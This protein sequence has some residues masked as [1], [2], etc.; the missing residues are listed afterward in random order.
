MHGE[1]T[2]EQTRAALQGYIFETLRDREWRALDAHLRACPAC[3]EVLEAEQARLAALDALP[4]ESAPPGLAERTLARMPVDADSR[5][6]GPRWAPLGAAAGVIVLLA[7]VLIPV[8]TQSRE[9]ARR[10]STQN[11]MKQLGLVFKMYGNESEGEQ[12]PRLA[13]ATEAWAPELDPLRGEFITDPDILVS[14]QHPEQRTLKQ[15][16]RDAWAGSAPDTGTAEQLM[17]ESFGYLGYTIRNEDDFEALRR[18][19]H[20]GTLPPP[21]EALQPDPDRDPILPLREGIERFLITDIN[22]PAATSASQSTIPVLVEIATW[23]YKKS[24]DRYKGANVLYMDGHVEFV[25]YQQRPGV[26]ADAS[27]TEQDEFPV[28]AAWALI[29]NAAL[30]AG[31]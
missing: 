30:D 1:A 9:A 24:V 16:L 10:A 11:T 4:R 31:L 8:F 29:T 23:K 18:A 2:C 6:P 5:Q 20:A 25:R 15:A 13:T 12:W 19:R 7:M 21:G 26:P 17:G 22:N 27:G 28:S 14:E 3:R